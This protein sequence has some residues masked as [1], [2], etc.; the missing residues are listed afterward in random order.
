MTTEQNS[1]GNYFSLI[2]PTF[3]RKSEVKRLLDSLVLQTHKN[4]EVL[5]IDQNDDDLM[6]GILKTYSA[7]LKIVHQKSRK[8]ASKARNLG[9]RIAKGDVIAFPDDDCWYPQDLLKNVSSF[10]DKN[11]QWD[12]LSTMI[13]DEK[14]TESVLRFH[15]KA[16]LVTRDTTWN[17]A[18]AV[19][20]FMKRFVVNKTG[21]F[22]EN[23]GPGCGKLIMAGEDMDY[24]LRIMDKGF[25]IHFDPNFHVCHPQ[26]KDS[27]EKKNEKKI[28]QYAVAGGFMMRVHKFG[29]LALAAVLVKNAGSVALSIIRG[30]FYK[31]KCTSLSIAGKLKGY[32]D[33]A[34]RRGF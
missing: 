29:L 9:I 7:T 2:V 10:F 20:L 3:G 19:T 33:P 27:D 24:I 28:Y 6:S 14:G 12:G 31:A 11:P 13:R 26:I 23:I 32:F 30:N 16:G 22:N 5:I 21:S 25:N 4:F 17:R 1:H 18:S 15:K 34:Y 8:G